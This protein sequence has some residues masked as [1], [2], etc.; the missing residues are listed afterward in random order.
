MTDSGQQRDAPPLILP[1][2]D[3]RAEQLEPVPLGTPPFREGKLQE[4]IATHPEVLPV[5][6]I[7]PAYAP[8]ICLG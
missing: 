8:L 4:L 6:E 7:E 2:R 3:G 5:A 1:D